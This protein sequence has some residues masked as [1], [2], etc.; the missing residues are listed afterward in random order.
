MVCM[1][2]LCGCFSGLLTIAQGKCLKA[3]VGQGSQV[4]RWA[5]N[6]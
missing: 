3:S 6:N 1:V 2:G 4:K 5:F